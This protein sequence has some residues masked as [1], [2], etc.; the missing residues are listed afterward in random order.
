MSFETSKSAGLSPAKQALLARWLKGEDT[1]VKASM[2]KRPEDAAV[3]MTYSQEGVW[4]NEQLTPGTSVYNQM[5]GLWLRFRVDENLLRRAVNAVIARHRAL[6]TRVPVVDGK[7]VVVIED[8]VVLPI[9]EIDLR[10]LAEPDLGPRLKLLMQEKVGLIYDLENG[11]LVN[12]WMIRVADDAVLVLLANHHLV[13]DGWSSGVISRDL[14]GFYSAFAR[15]QTKADLPELEAAYDDYAWWQRESLPADHFQKNLDYWKE[16]LG[17][18]QPA[19][20]LPLDRPRPANPT[21]V[22]DERRFFLPVELCDGIRA[23]SKREK[24]SVFMI[25]TA[26]FQTLLHR[27]SGAREVVVGT[28]VANRRQEVNHLVGFFVNMIPLK[29]Y[30]PGKL[31]FRN[32]LARVKETVLSGFANQQLPIGNLI[33]ELRRDSVLTPDTPLFQTSLVLQNTPLPDLRRYGYHLRA[34]KYES[35]VAQFEVTPADSQ[36]RNPTVPVDYTTQTS[37]FDLSLTVVDPGDRMEVVAEFGTEVL[38]PDTVEQLCGAFQ[39]LLTSLV[40]EPDMDLHRHP[41][42]DEAERQRLMVDWNRNPHPVPIQNCFQELFEETVRRYPEQP[43]VGDD[44]RTLSYAELNARA[45]ALARELINHGAGAETVVALIADRSIGF[46]TGMQA[47]FKAGAVYMPVAPSMPAGRAAGILNRAGCT[48]ILADDAGKAMARETADLCTDRPEI[49]SLSA[50][51]AAEPENLPRRRNSPQNLAYVIFTSGSTGLPKGAMLTHAGMINHIFSKI[52]DLDLTADD[53]IAQTAPQSF[54]ISVWQ[55]L[56][57]LVK[58]GRVTVADNDTIRQPRA[59]FDFLIR[60]KVTIYETVPSFLHVC[61]DEL[62]AIAPERRPRFFMRK[63]MVTGEALPPELCRR[64]LTLY[65]LIPLI[66]AYGPTE[67]SDDVTHHV[68]AEPPPEDMINMPIGRSIINT[69]NYVLDPNLHPMPQGIPGEQWVGG[70]GVG[71]GYLNDPSRTARVFMPNPFSKEPGA[72]LY[73]TGDLVRLLP[74]ETIEFLGRIDFQVKIRGFRIE[75]GEIEAVL[76]GHPRI[77]NAVVMARESVSG[78]KWL[79][80]YIVPANGQAPDARSWLKDKLPDYMVPAALVTMDAIPLTSNG[81]VDRKALPEPSRVEKAAKEYAAPRNDRER[82]LIDLLGELLGRQSVGI[83]DNFFEIGG[84]SIK[85][86]QLTH[87]LRALGYVMSPLQ[88]F[89]CR[90]V[91]E[92]AEALDGAGPETT[93]TNTPE[94]FA[95]SGLDA[96]ASAEVKARFQVPVLDAYPLTPT[97]QG[98][99]F[100]T[101]FT[102]DSDL[103]YQQFVLELQGELDAD[104]FEKAWEYTIAAHPALRTAFIWEGLSEPLQVVVDHNHLAVDRRNWIG[105]AGAEKRL[106]AYLSED[107]ARHVDPRRPLLMRPALITT[108][109][110]RFTLVWSFHHLLMDGW[111]MPLVLRDTLDSYRA[112][113][114]GAVPKLSSP[115][116]FVDYVAHLRNL[117]TADAE[118]FWTRELSGFDE[119]APLQIDRGESAGVTTYESRTV[120]LERS[121]TDALNRM[122]RAGRLTLN[123]VMQAVWAL[124]IARYS[125]RNDVVFGTAT[126][127]RDTA[128]TGVEDMVGVF[129]NTLP[130]RARIDAEEKPHLWLHRFHRRFQELTA[131][132]QAPLSKI[133]EWCGRP[134]NGSESRLFDTL[135]V[136]HNYPLEAVA[137]NMHGF[138][139]L[140]VRAI[141]RTGY[142][143]TLTIQPGEEIRL[144]LV[145]DRTRFSD[146]NI[147]GLLKHYRQLL[148]G[149]TAD[150]DAVG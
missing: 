150:K 24:V 65:P 80:A 137:E 116:P 62:E 101:L 77:N 6:R 46:L 54:D 23:L 84:D 7:P 120:Y 43:A 97:Q 53:I 60:H 115:R 81:K 113:K 136:F 29:T 59:M 102:P 16:H 8:T 130:V 55:F 41:L 91:A 51:R 139:L 148:A 142:P 117:D 33:D 105:D 1:P 10:H 44:R 37:E 49:L 2:P 108:A 87:R 143:I 141:E 9:P 134:R 128:L 30:F 92:L 76:A 119:P 104:L 109:E 121:A 100:H 96:G 27:I 73:R 135:V 28:A 94:P 83:D 89:Q 25:L 122:S 14:I 107:Q 26:A 125:G 45:N 118:I 88:I 56:A 75:L 13:G 99:L 12:A 71:R 3:P 85:G 66:N 34:L 68:I 42:I 70:I 103:Y 132:G 149:V 127:G 129:I 144:G 131:R 21:R 93:E 114:Q 61:L 110:N 20:A 106:N 90:T 4:L 19:M 79:A 147:E 82:L 126:A 57:L 18:E 74:T 22:G 48:L 35:M 11:P 15:G 47:V 124:L 63:L 64:W 72:R 138:Q 40:D 50:P 67:C 39:H 95:L 146:E 145:Y 86:I 69:Q 5:L 78:E 98:M 52:V 38:K 17:A 58:G 123:T 140:G 32:L 36:P 133:Q 111:S 112:L 31:S